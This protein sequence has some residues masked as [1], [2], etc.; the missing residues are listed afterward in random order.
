MNKE[1]Y[2]LRNLSV[3][4]IDIS[5]TNIVRKFNRLNLKPIK[6][7]EYENENLKIVG[8]NHQVDKSYTNFVEK[9]LTERLSNDSSQREKMVHS[10]SFVYPSFTNSKNVIGEFRRSKEPPEIYKPT[11]NVKG[12]RD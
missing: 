6:P 5:I 3:S 8:N 11:Q 1:G 10:K 4:I 9:P 7:S 2:I 12:I